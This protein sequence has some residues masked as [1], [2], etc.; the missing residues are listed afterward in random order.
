MKEHSLAACQ[1]SI[2]PQICTRHLASSTRLALQTNARRP[3]CRRI[4]RVPVHPSNLALS[5]VQVR[6]C[7]IDHPFPPPGPPSTYTTKG[8]RWRFPPPTPKLPVH[9]D[10]QKS[11]KRGLVYLSVTCWPVDNTI[12][13]SPS[14]VAKPA[15]GPEIYDQLMGLVAIGTWCG[16]FRGGVS[17]LNRWALG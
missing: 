7:Q 17:G 1:H 4:A 8:P 12:R 9:L 15:E 16:K 6:H 3:L 14:W 2:G 5:S 11:L 13:S 10:H